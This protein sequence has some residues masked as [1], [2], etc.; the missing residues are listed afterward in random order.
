[1]VRTF[2][3]FGK[4][5]EKNDWTNV[6][7]FHM[8]LGWPLIRI[9]F[10]KKQLPWCW[11]KRGSDLRKFLLPKTKQQ[12]VTQARPFVGFLS[13]EF[14]CPLF[15]WT[16]KQQRRSAGFFSQKVGKQSFL[17]RRSLPFA[18]KC[19]SLCVRL[20]KENLAVNS[21]TAKGKVVRSLELRFILS[22]SLRIW[23]L[24]PFVRIFCFD[25]V[26]SANDRFLRYC[27]HAK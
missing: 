14:V 25:A 9:F 26:Q 4:D 3:V 17:L 27:C 11:I 18:V 19:F 10:Q 24:S 23:L 16:R 5:V 6:G 2:T 7:F 20:P 1:M 15:T 13:D 8:E 21:L 12:N 22:V